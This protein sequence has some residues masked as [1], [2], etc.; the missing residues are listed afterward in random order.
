MAALGSTFTKL[1]LMSNEELKITQLTQFIKGVQLTNDNTLTNSL[2]HLIDQLN[3]RVIS[4]ILMVVCNI[5]MWLSFTI[6]LSTAPNT[7]HASIVNS[8]TNFI[9]TVRDYCLSPPG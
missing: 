5:T 4:L 8:S 1:G 6:A 3:L 9:A 7:L 2:Y